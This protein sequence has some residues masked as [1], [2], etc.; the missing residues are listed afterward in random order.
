MRRWHLKAGLWSDHDYKTFFSV[1]SW[2]FRDR[3]WIVSLRPNYNH[4]CN[5]TRTNG[6]Y[7]MTQ[8]DL[9]NHCLWDSVPDVDC[10]ACYHLPFIDMSHHILFHHLFLTQTHGKS[11]REYWRKQKVK[12]SAENGLT[13][14]WLKWDAMEAI[15]GESTSSAP[16]RVPICPM[17]GG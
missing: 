2:M 8:Q 7:L 16:K 9:N 13:Y 1:F 15:F 4:N 5:R 11:D 3:Y 12:K 17:S 6:F 10:A 14:L